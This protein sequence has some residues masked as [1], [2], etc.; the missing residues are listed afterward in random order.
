MIVDEYRIVLRGLRELLGSRP[1]FDVR[2]EA[3]TRDE[4]L[5][6]VDQVK[7]TLV[8]TGLNFRVADGIGLVKAIAKGHPEARILVLSVHD[9]NLFAE[10]V[11]RAGA[12]GYVPKT[13]SLDRV[14]A[15]IDNVLEGDLYLSRDVR[16]R[17][18]Q[19][20]S[21]GSAPLAARATEALT[22]RELQVFG[23]LG[24]GESTRE[25]ADALGLSV[26]TIDTHRAK[27]MKK[28]G[29]DDGVQ[30]LQR[31]VEWVRSREDGS[32]GGDGDRRSR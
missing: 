6:L 27:M 16:N 30:L 23:R 9:E 2:G 7:P 5:A 14:L 18:L 15:A 22:E 24:R 21:E 20:I 4:A 17:I 8:V 25:I 31:A 3:T 10:R 1:D 12:H 13:A 11:I 26:K 28:L 19:R 29:L 32:G